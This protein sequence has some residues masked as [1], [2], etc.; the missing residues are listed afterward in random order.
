MLERAPRRGLCGREERR[1][2]AGKMYGSGWREWAIMD[3]KRVETLMVGIGGRPEGKGLVCGWMDGEVLELEI[4][5][6]AVG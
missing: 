1:C 3:Q 6:V 4:S 5:P 2:R